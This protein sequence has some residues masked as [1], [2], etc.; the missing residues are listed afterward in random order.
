M[1]YRHPFVLFSFS[2]LLSKQ[3]FLKSMTYRVY[4]FT[5]LSVNTLR[6]NCSKYCCKNVSAFGLG[7]GLT[8]TFFAKTYR[9]AFSRINQMVVTLMIGLVI[10]QAAELAHI[11]I[12]KTNV[13]REAS[14]IPL[15]LSWI[16]LFHTPSLLSPHAQL[17][18]SVPDRNLNHRNF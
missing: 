17:L 18:C 15:N 10:G 9:A 13:S 8:S 14:S 11:S 3:I 16:S 7:L 5:R 1:P 6:E 2:Q 12:L 4:L